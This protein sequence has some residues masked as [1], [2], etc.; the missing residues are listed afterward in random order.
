M[1]LKDIFKRFSFEGIKLTASGAEI[2]ISYK[3]YDR[4]AAWL[5]YVELLT[6]IT[7]QPIKDDVGDEKAALKSIYQIFAIT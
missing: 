1:K 3:K 7:T 6:R 4:D 5:M 2:E